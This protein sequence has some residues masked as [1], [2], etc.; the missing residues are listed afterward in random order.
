MKPPSFEYHAP[1]S[2]DEALKLLGQYRGEARILAGGQ[3]LVPLLNFRLANPAA[4]IDINKIGEL[5]YIKEDNGHVRLGAL[6]RQRAIEF[7]PVVNHSLPLLGEATRMVGHPPT[8]T[9]GTIGGS[10]AHADPAAEYPC[11]VTALDGEIVIRGP[12][13]ERSV[14]AA[15]FFQ[16]LMATAV[17]AGEMLVEVRL[18]AMAAN[19]G[20]AFEEFSRRHG[21]FALAAVA[22]MVTMEGKQCATVRL[23]AAGVGATPLRLRAAEEILKRAEPGENLIDAAAARAAELV[24]LDSDIHATAAYRRHLTHTLTRRALTRAIA[25]ARGQ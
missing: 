8:R 14:H 10:I 17:A 5:S 3:S 24:D 6:T 19:A 1:A 15:E 9:R 7:S 25:R 20:W 18:P 11:V 2:V 12:R 13:G 23:A 4:L 21:D 16:G 22:A